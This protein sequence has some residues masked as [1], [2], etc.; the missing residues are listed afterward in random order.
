MKKRIFSILL[1][2]C[3]VLM[4]FPV[5]AFAEG[6]DTAELQALL[7]AGD[8]VTLDKDYTIT[9][10]LKVTN[11]VTIDLN[12]H[13]VKMT[14]SGSVV[15]V[16]GS[17]AHLTLQD[18]NP[19]ATHT[20]L[21]AGGVLT[22]GNATNGGGV[23]IGARGSFAMNGGTIY[24]CTATYDGGG[25]W[26][27]PYAAFT[28]A[29]GTIYNCTA[30]SGGGVA[31]TTYGTFTMNSGTIRNC[32]ALFGGGVY[33]TSDSTFIMAGGA[34]E[35]CTAT[36]EG[37][38]LRTGTT[39]YANGGIVKGT[40]S[41]PGGP[42]T[43][44]N[45]SG[46]TVFYGEVTNSGTI[47]GGIYY[48]GILNKSSGTV[49]GTYHTVSF[50][51]NGGSGS[52]PT[53]WFVNIDTATALQPADPTKDDYVFAGWYN[54]DTKYDFTKAV[55][56][57]ITLTAKWVSGGVTTEAELKE[58]LGAGITSIKLLGNVTLTS[59]LSLSDKV[60]TLDLNGHTLKGNL[61][62]A[63]T[64]AAPQSI[65]T[66]IDSNPAGGG[67]L[68]GD[69]E[70]TRGSYGNASHLYAN[71]GTITGKVSLNS[72]IAKM[73][74]TS[75]TPAAI[76]GYVGNYGEIHGGILYGFFEASCIKEN[77]VTFRNGSNRYAVE[78]VADGSKVAAPIAPSVPEGMKFT[79][80][81]TDEALTEK[82][83]FGSTLPE[84]ITLY[85]GIVPIT[86]IV[87]YD[88][89]AEFGLFVDLKTHGEDLTLRG[90][91]F[92]REGYV[93]TGWMGSDG[94]FYELGGV[95]TT[96]ADV[97][98]RAV[99]DEIITLSVPFTTTVKL[100]G[101]T[102]PGETVFTLE[103]VAANTDAESYADVTVSASVTTNGEGSYTGTMTLTGPFGQLR[104]MLCE[105]AFVK[106]VN[107]GAANWTY[108]DTV[109]GLLLEEVAA[110]ASTD[111]A[112]PEYTVLILP[113]T[114]E[115]TENGVYY[116]LD[117]DADPLDHMSFTNTYTKS[118]TEPTEPSKPTE[119]TTNIPSTGDNSNPA[120]WLAL[121]AVSAAGVIG[122]GVH[123][124]RRRSPQAE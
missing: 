33:G 2:L 74:C 122:T 118:T 62:L 34:I 29:G 78:V 50:D 12:G 107:A 55:T 32:S 18:S 41:N 120:L 16:E 24:N 13:V 8:T 109:W 21:P 96:D 95:Y 72:Y 106:Q 110:L 99:W 88:G 38:G 100:G 116:D 84:S 80:W 117:W 75:D 98:M 79:G 92:S 61:K 123:S 53:Q 6:D 15:I 56:E 52:A 57:N 43:S 82:Y 114:C 97:T 103:I 68:N 64:S 67:V 37:G 104:N 5:T 1:C 11:T 30:Q 85:A 10:S 35:D 14:S 124:K 90:N 83:E 65:L 44:T 89:G 71:G 47:S 27:G 70:L 3:M 77:T 93:Q 76:K 20:G 36:A 119:P 91:I 121:L 102:A 69:I 31:V 26:C 28:M 7:D 58:A 63:D 25:V 101:N 73:F 59:T 22:G 66:L 86:Y 81:Y 111:D 108:D 46:C 105:G 49:T 4:L 51:L 87:E 23:Y 40:V 113:A 48:G 42:I 19:T 112:A 17:A 94:V 115:E 39:T 54:G 45:P 9:S 60:I